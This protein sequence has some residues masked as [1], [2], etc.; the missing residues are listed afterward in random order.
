MKQSHRGAR[1]LCL[2]PIDKATS[3]LLSLWTSSINDA[4]M[5]A[6]HAPFICTKTLKKFPQEIYKI[7]RVLGQAATE[8]LGLYPNFEALEKV[9]KQ[10]ARCVFSSSRCFECEDQYG[11]IP[12][13][14][15]TLL[16]GM[17]FS[18][19][20]EFFRKGIIAQRACAA[21]IISYRLFV[22]VRLVLQQLRQKG[23]TRNY[24]DLEEEFD[25]YIRTFNRFSP[26]RTIEPDFELFAIPLATFPSSNQRRTRSFIYLSDDSEWVDKAFGRPHAIHE[27]NGVQNPAYSKPMKFADPPHND[28]EIAEE[29]HRYKEMSRLGGFDYTPPAS[30]VENNFYPT[31]GPS[32]PPY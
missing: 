4:I 32:P 18:G 26:W 30:P 23:D 25:G 29:R 24:E 27:T 10:L 21:I 17:A 11:G 12:G 8:Y 31:P 6:S 5:T 1:R 16:D 9:E 14:L 15:L 3:L 28:E 13:R 20:E 7:E 22:V 19:F 2:E